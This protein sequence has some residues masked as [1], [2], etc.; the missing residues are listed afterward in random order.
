[1]PEK[2]NV[3]VVDD[4]NFNREVL[5]T[6]LKLLGYT[7]YEAESAEKA[8]DVLEKSQIDILLLDIKLPGMDGLE[9]LEKIQK[10]K[11][12]I[13]VIMMTAFESVKS[14]VDAIEKG[15][16][17]YLIKPIE[18][19][20]LELIIKKALKRHQIEQERR[21]A[22]ERRM[23]AAKEFFDSAV[24]TDLLIKQLRNEV[25]ILLK[26]LGLPPKYKK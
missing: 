10:E 11:K 20:H 23:K 24:E 9:Y 15:A 18:P 3:L 17:D 5:I 13:I 21:L 8:A 16:Y 4:D 26:E 1:M 19:R 25:N 6:K 12:D 7:A 14:A 2:L 22:V